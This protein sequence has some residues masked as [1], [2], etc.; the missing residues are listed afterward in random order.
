MYSADRCTI[1]TH[2]QIKETR[3]SVRDSD[4][5]L[6]KMAIGHHIN[7][8]SHTIEKRINTKADTREEHHELIN[9]DEGEQ[10]Q[11]LSPIYTNPD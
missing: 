9:V 6:Q 1:H 8:R 7:D 2:T 10:C 5:G 3:K 4:S 11:A